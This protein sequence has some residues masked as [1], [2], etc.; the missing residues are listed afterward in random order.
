MKVIR[1]SLKRLGFGFIY[2][3]ENEKGHRFSWIKYKWNTVH[4]CWAFSC[5]S[6]IGLFQPF[7]LTD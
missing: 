4:N 1:F 7:D 5:R 6:F 3:A 2:R